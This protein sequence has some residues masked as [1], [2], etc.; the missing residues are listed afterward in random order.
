M[1]VQSKASFK[2]DGRL[3]GRKVKTERCVEE[4]KKSLK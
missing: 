4:I 2:S 3:I 1:D